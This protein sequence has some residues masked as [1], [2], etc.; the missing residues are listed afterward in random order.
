MLPLIPRYKTFYQRD[1]YDCYT[2]NECFVECTYD[3]GQRFAIKTKEYGYLYD[4]LAEYNANHMHPGNRFVSPISWNPAVYL[5]YCS[6]KTFR[7]ITAGQPIT[8]DTLFTLP[9]N[10]IRKVYSRLSNKQKL[11]VKKSYDKLTTSIH[12]SVR[13]IPVP[14]FVLSKY[15][16][17][18]MDN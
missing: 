2:S 3:N 14:Y 9:A 13:N 4:A 17:Y 6:W 7:A 18:F 1:R 5:N 16:Q 12:D 10:I 11:A 8:G 15:L